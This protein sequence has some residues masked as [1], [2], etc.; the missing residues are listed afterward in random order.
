MGNTCASVHIH[1]RG[2]AEAAVK[3]VDRAYGK[4]GYVP[5]MKAGQATQYLVILS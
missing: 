3:A 4:L 5:A 1:W 2:P